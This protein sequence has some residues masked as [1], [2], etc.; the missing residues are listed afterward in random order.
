MSGVE[1]VRVPGRPDPNRYRYTNE[2]PE[3][4]MTR[5][6]DRCVDGAIPPPPEGCTTGV[7]VMPRWAQL[8]DD[9]TG[10]PGPWVLEV[11]FSC[12]GDRDYPF[13]YDDFTR[14]PITPSPLTLQPDRS[15]VYAGLD[16]IGLTDGTSQGFQVELRGLTFQ[17]GAIP[18]E[19][20]WDF[21]D[22]SDLL[23]TTDP[24]KPYPN[25]TVAHRYTA[26]GT[27]TPVLTTYWM[28]VFRET[29]FDPW[30]EI[31]GTGETITTG[32]PLTIYAPR[33]RLV[34]DPLD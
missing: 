9:G 8:R 17:V 4:Y 14:L 7:M 23:T 21:G 29:I 2:C 22:G 34:E 20:V 13:G 26:S 15:W 25:Q 27:A 30:T 32:T 11:G 5:I 12:P 19:Y 18:I 10:V 24:G 6:P 3:N 33:T 1:F 31:P 16:T 28:G